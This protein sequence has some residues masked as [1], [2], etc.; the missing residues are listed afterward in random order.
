[1]GLD[2]KREIK[3]HLRQNKELQMNIRGQ[4]VVLSLSAA[5]L[6]AMP[7]VGCAG[8]RNKGA[9]KQWVDNATTKWNGIRSTALLDMAQ[10]QFDSGALDLAEKTVRDAADVDSSNP[11]LHL[12]AGRIALEK[13]QLERAYRFFEMALTHDA[14]NP[15]PYYYQGIV[16][17]RWKQYNAALD[18]YQKAYDL[19]MESAGKLLAVAE[20]M[21]A[22]ERVDDAIMLL[23]EK[24][25]YFDQNSGCR[26]ML[27]H[28][29]AMRSD[30][31][32][33]VENFRTAVMLDTQNVR[34]RE[35]LAAAQIGGEMY[36]DAALT[37]NEI[38]AMPGFEKRSDLRRS[39]ALAECES[40]RLESARQI[41][42]QLT[43][44]DSSNMN[45]WVRLGELCWKLQDMGGAMIAAN[46]T[47]AL[48]P[49]RHEGYVLA[50]LVWQKRGRLD[51]ALVSFDQAASLDST[52]ATP[53]ILR[54][55]LLQKTQRFQAAAEAYGEALEREPGDA[56]VERLLAQ[57][58]EVTP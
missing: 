6:F 45:D 9:H 26:A 44:Q 37:L 29:Y 3:P 36:E 5:A 10:G 7:L 12:L 56:R 52:S 18:C 8:N 19:D 15:Q 24:K 22:L 23:E 57:V 21:V 17:Q 47:I 42:I 58:A 28:L 20:T 30:H 55:L 38:L 14:E 13:G 43:R 25:I 49:N 31:R 41:Y 50:G 4:R 40:G 35:E 32:M 33:A 2:S 46:R 39:L 11:G 53:L 48:A 51:D 16:L 27:G 34:I 1:V 54:G